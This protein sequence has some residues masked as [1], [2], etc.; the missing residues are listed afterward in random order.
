M[1]EAGKYEM[2]LKSN[3]S[4]V[5][6]K[7]N[8]Q[9]PCLATNLGLETLN[10]HI[11]MNQSNPKSL[12]YE[13]NDN[14]EEEEETFLDFVTLNNFKELGLDESFINLDTCSRFVYLTKST[15]TY[16]DH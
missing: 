1:P 6:Q 14:K 12:V 11:N 9:F 5:S 10:F 2:N 3:R 7:I 16:E 8:A 15:K 13:L 4:P